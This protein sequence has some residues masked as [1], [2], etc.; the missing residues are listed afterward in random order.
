MTVS[1]G[2]IAYLTSEYPK[3]SHTFIQRE[4]EGVRATGLEVITC[5]IRKPRPADL[6]GPEEEAAY[7]DTFYLLKTAKNPIRLIS[8]HM[9]AL[10]TAPR[11]YFRAL[12][13][14][15]RTAPPGAKALLWQL[16]YFAEAAVLVGHLKSKG[17]GHLHTH[18]ANS[19]CSV[20]MLASEMSGISFSFTMHG[21]DEFFEAE[22]WRL[23]EKVARAQFVSCISHFC[24]SQLM[25][26]AGQ[27]HWSKL[28]IIHCGIDPERYDRPRSSPGKNLLFVGRLSGVKGAPILLD[29]IAILIPK[30][31]ELQL[32]FV[33]DGPERPALEAQ[34]SEAGIDAHVSFAGFQSQDVVAD[35]LSR[36]DIFVLPSF[37]EGLPVV[38]MEALASQVPVV[39]T[40]IAGVSELV[41]DGVNGYLIPPSDIKSLVNCLEGMLLNTTAH[42]KMGVAGRAKVSNEFNIK[43][44]TIRLAELLKIYSKTPQD[45]SAQ[46]QHQ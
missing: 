19:G 32:T 1:H 30:H 31:P 9:K 4:V 23:D 45:S 18:F 28:H 35:Y 40:H 12:W 13:L 46:K 43:T 34:A 10:T 27:A 17:A 14:A 5:S 29:A 15:F 6:T 37:A 8:D 33:G 11:G 7:D 16:F 22:R 44:E 26:F 39:T 25:L 24:R 36:T 38:L 41:E 42:A 21:P 2:P 3:V 20:A